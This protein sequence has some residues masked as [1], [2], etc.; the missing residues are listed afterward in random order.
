MMSDQLPGSSP[1]RP[2]P[3]DAASATL[4][5]PDPDPEGDELLAEQI[6][7]AQDSVT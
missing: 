6:A 4:D 1:A 2:D 5:E 7:E 3:E